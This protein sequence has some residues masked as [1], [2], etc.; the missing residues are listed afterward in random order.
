MEAFTWRPHA[1]TDG[2]DMLI[3]WVLVEWPLV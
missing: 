2:S 3:I 1:G